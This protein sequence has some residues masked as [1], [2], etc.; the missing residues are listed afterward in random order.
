MDAFGACLNSSTLRPFWFLG[1]LY[2]Y[3][4]RSSLHAVAPRWRFATQLLYGQ[5]W[6]L[7]DCS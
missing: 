2:S 7:G 4:K 1:A 3:T 5:V 6:H